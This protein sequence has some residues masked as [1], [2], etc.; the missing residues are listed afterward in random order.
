MDVEAGVREAR[1]RAALA[2][3]I[4]DEHASGA[5]TRLQQLLALAR[6]KPLFAAGGALLVGVI[7]AGLIAGRR[8]R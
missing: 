2:R 3:D 1:R 4:V 8:R 6:E 7:V 5:A